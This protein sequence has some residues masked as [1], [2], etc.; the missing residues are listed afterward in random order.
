MTCTAYCPSILTL[1]GLS[2]TLI[3]AA[4]TAWA[5]TISPEQA[6]TISASRYA[7]ET[8]EEGLN[9]PAAQNLLKQSRAAKHGLI[10]IATGTVLQ[11]VG[12]AWGLIV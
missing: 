5:A 12:T 7:P 6:V 2:L 10:L 11:I 1:V 3:G 9:L 8:I 4:I